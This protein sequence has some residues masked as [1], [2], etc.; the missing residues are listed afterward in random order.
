MAQNSVILSLCL[1][2]SYRL[3]IAVLLN[4]DLFAIQDI[5]ALI[6]LVDADA[7]Y[8]IVGVDVLLVMG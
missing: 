8:G 6:G 4:H 7:L 2:R 3:M 5:E 1:C